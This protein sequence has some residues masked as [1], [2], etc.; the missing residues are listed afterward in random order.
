[1]SIGKREGKQQALRVGA[2]ELPSSSGHRFYEKLN[3][4]RGGL[5]S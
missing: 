2:G 1:M 4:L 3:G 5:C